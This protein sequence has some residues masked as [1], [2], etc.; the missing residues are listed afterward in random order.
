VAGAAA[1]A[2][3]PYIARVYAPHFLPIKSCTIARLLKSIK[4]QIMELVEDAYRMGAAT[5]IM[6]CVPSQI[7]DPD[8]ADD[9]IQKN[10]CEG[11]ID[12]SW[13]DEREIFEMRLED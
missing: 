10:A 1:A 4:Q 6:A 3:S 11:M 13:L 5:G 12:D 2:L 7:E 9:W 8:M